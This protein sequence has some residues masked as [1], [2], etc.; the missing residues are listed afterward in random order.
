VAMAESE[1]VKNHAAFIWSVADLL[2]GD[3]KQSEYGR[4]ILPLT[5]IRRL[6][7]VLERTKPKVL[8]RAEKLA[9]KVANIDPVMEQVTG[10]EKFC[11]TSKLDMR[12][13]LDD[14]G[15]IADQLHV[16]SGESEIRR[17]I[18]EHDWLDTVVALPD[19]LFYNTGISTY[20]WIVT[21][22]KT[23]ERR[24]SVQLIDARD[25][26][27]KMRKSLGEKRKEL[28]AAQIAEV[29]R[30]YHDHV[31]G[32]R[33]KILP[34]ESFGFLR[35]TVERPLRAKGEITDGTIAA[36]LATKAVVK[37][38]ED[39]RAVIAKLLAAN[40]GT[41]T[42]SA[43]EMEAALHLDPTL[44][45]PQ[46]KAV[47][48]ALM[49][50]DPD[51]EPQRDIVSFGDT[52]LERDY[53]FCRGLAAL[54]R[55][56][57]GETVDLGDD[58]ELTHLRLQKQF[59][60]SVALTADEGEITTLFDG[61]GKRHEPE[62]KR[63]SSIIERFNERFGTDWTDAD[64]LFPDAI[65]EDLVNDERLQLQAGANNLDTF[66]VGFDGLYLN[67]IAARLDRNEKVAGQLLDDDELR[68]QLVA[69][70]LPRIYARARVARQRTCPIGELLGAD[71]EDSGLE[72]KSTLRWDIK[73]ES[74]KTK[75]PDKAVVKTVGGFLNAEFGGTLLIGVA[76]DGTVYG[77]EADYR[78]FS[79][80]GERGDRDLFGQHLQN[81]TLGRLGDAA[82]TLVGWEFHTVDGADLCRVSVEPADFPVF[83]G[84]GDD[85]RIFWWR[86][87]TGTKPVTDE[88]ERRRIIR[89]RFGNG[90]T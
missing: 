70:Y 80:R 84:T 41:V 67:A 13:L 47:L 35:I 9:G 31:E 32:D 17:W 19:Q 59:E 72:Y 83:E 56:H 81:L 57:S 2:R 58:L 69:D 60:G 33:V 42:P 76:D 28:S 78:T 20:F 87:P 16:Y 10:G 11:N 18:I 34:N 6:D 24:G 26:F 12:R 54:L 5:V 51:A 82:G 52:R 48:D 88:N 66:R 36:A 3:Y 23:P 44:T 29:T 4:V 40:R 62:P 77:L 71:R 49:I 79:K 30:L 25:L 37:L 14:P 50:P 38:T 64:R 63:L 55:G 86:Y 85:D 39:D 43:P 75:I 90:T 53:L 15:S 61:T 8:E 73:A 7:C 68:A 74:H 22:R 1:T 46:A 45:K 27:V 89:R 65:E 21:N